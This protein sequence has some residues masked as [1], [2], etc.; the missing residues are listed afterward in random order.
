MI[1][2]EHVIDLLMQSEKH[3]KWP[4]QGVVRCFWPPLLSGQ[5]R[6]RLENGRL[7]SLVTWAMMSDE[8]SEAYRTGSRPLLP[9]DWSSGPHLWFMDM[10][11]IGQAHGLVRELESA[12]ADN[13]IHYA[14]ALR[15]GRDGVRRLHTYVSRRRE[16]IAA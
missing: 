4:L 9:T 10:I 12:L 16:R 6:A 8:A 3:R 13:G 1:T 15:T 7:V 14:R 5:Y 11:A 2:V